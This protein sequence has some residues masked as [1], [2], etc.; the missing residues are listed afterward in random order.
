MK[1]GVLLIP[2]GRYRLGRT[3]HVWSGIRLIGYGATRPVLV[4][5]ESTPGFQEGDGKYLVHFVSWRPRAGEPIRDGNPGTFYSAISN[6]DIEIQGGNPAAIGVRFH[7]AQHCYLAHMELHVGSGR[8][9][10]EDIGNMAEDLHFRGGEY[11]ILT[12]KTAPS[13]PFVLIDSS[14]EGQRVAAI[15]TEEAG[16]TLVRNRFRNVPTV[17]SINP[18]RAEQLWIE[19]AHFLDVTGPA[20]VVSNERNPRTQINLQNVVC[21]RVPLLVRFRESGKE[22]AGAGPLYVVKDFSHGL[23]VSDLGAAP[24]IGTTF[25]AAPLATAPPP[26]PSDVPPLPA[27]ETWVS[28]RSLGAVGDGT[29]DDTEV[30]R[31]AVAE[32]RTIFLPAGRYR[33]SDTVTLRPDTVLVGLSPISTVIALDDGTPAFQGPGAP[34][35]LLETAKGG[36]AIVTGIGLDTGGDNGR[37]VAAKWTAGRGSLLDDVR[38]LGGHGTYR[39]DGS[40][41]DVRRAWERIYNSTRTADPDPKRRWDSQYCSLWITDGG[42]G[43][44]KDI[45]SPSSFAQAGVCITNT[46][47]GGRIYAMS[48]EHHV[49]NEV[50]LRNASNWKIY[51]L[52]T[53]EERGESAQALPLAIEDS[54]DVTFAN[55]FAYRVVSSLEPFPY[56]VAVS[57]STGIHFRGLHVYSDSKVAFDASV[58]DRT[59]GVELRA[60][61][62]ARLTISGDPPRPRPAAASAML[63]PGA[64]LERLA[65][66]FHD[67]SGAAVDAR[68]DLFF[69]DTRRHTIYRWSNARRAL[70]IVRDSPLDPAQLGFDEEGNLLVV[71]YAGKGSVFAFRPGS[72]EGEL[73]QLEP[74]PASVRRG[75]TPLL[76]V[77]RWRNENDFVASATERRPYHYVSPDGSVF[78]PAGEDFV[79]G[80]LYYG[81]KMADVL[82]AFRLAPATPGRPFY[83]CEESGSRTWRFTVGNDGTLGEPALF[84]EEGCSGTAVDGAGRVWIAGEQV[85]VYDP[86]GRRLESIEVPERPTAVVFG[87]E[88]GRTL[89]VLTRRSLYAART[90][91]RR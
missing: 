42:G 69:V 45:W 85:S 6:V 2:S 38:F 86:S 72:S 39:L 83:V 84:A 43:V 60:Y 31:K 73:L 17:V 47:T 76:A 65:G 64:S 80:A 49:R 1:Q 67:I 8:A 68:G 5:G 61:E 88:D 4:L 12:R 9:G 40:W 56:A 77:N 52:Q 10:L 59:R 81:A 89:F 79:S 25:E 90:S 7:V 70:A 51:G 26:V 18:D 23:E 35:A 71:S 62:L 19:D 63:A 41:D 55:L 82:R 27:Q 87:G 32:H 16:L 21:E 24:V 29:A 48:V 22:V 75:R 37:A 33:V 91:G 74:R 46:S 66:G 14:F 50:I 53:E 13:W 58:Y 36:G 34:K 20:L 78:V 3:I 57:S 11:G 15:R 54:S 44:F 28:L 30:L